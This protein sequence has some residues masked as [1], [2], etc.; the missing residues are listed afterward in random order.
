MTSEPGRSGVLL[1]KNC[2]V[3]GQP[4]TSTC[5]S[6][7]ARVILGRIAAQRDG[8]ATT[9][10]TTTTTTVPS[11]STWS[12]STSLT[13][14]EP[15]RLTT[16]V[17]SS[18][19]S[20]WSASAVLPAM[21]HSMRGLPPGPHWSCKGLLPFVPPLEGLRRMDRAA[22]RAR[23]TDRG[24]AGRLCRRLEGV[25]PGPPQGRSPHRGTMAA[26]Q[27]QK[28]HPRSRSPGFRGACRGDVRPRRPRRRPQQ[29]NNE[30]GD[31]CSR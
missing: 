23:W 3:A 24:G 6:L 5:W 29:R 16:L 4:G 11:H 12:G 30:P 17:S 22:T 21:S 10:T 8:A 19:H 25:A 28:R 13:C 2:A 15:D 27:P 26:T 14:G 18:S 7:V 9:T 31:L 1:A 20:I